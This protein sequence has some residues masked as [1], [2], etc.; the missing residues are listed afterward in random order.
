MDDFLSGY[1]P[2]DK[3]KVEIGDLVYHP[4]Y[5][6][7]KVLSKR[8]DDEIIQVNFSFGNVIKDIRIGVVSGMMMKKAE[9]DKE[10]TIRVKW[11]KDGKLEKKI[12]R[13][14]VFEKLGYSEEVSNLSEYVWNL[15]KKG[16]RII[17]LSDYSRRNMSIRIH[18][19]FLEDYKDPNDSRSMVTLH[20]NVEYR[21][22][23][24]I[25]IRINTM[26][27]PT[28]MSLE[29][30][31]KHAY[32]FIKGGK[33]YFKMKDSKHLGQFTEI[34]SENEF[35]DKFIYIMYLI[36][37]NEIVAYYHSDIRNYK[38]N[39]HK[40]KNNIRKFIKYSSLN[41]FYKYINDNDISEII[42]NIP[43]EEKNDVMNLYYYINKHDKK[44]FNLGEERFK[45]EKFKDKI[46]D[47]FKKI[48]NI[49]DYVEY[50]DEEIDIFYKK[51]EIEVERKKK[52]F[53]KY[54]GRLYSYFS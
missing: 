2:I 30:E 35:T 43:R 14:D 17:D 21:K 28:I 34:K 6:E 9:T 38:Q 53:L 24:N 20:S 19:L 42:K 11:Y 12:I 52:V 45:F 16:E 47:F 3:K 4:K 26:F 48:L 7:G 51:F 32:D 49:K 29:H 23:K 33:D 27:R 46:R 31:L 5:G 18:L 25:E 54:I 37:I 44:Y 40:F 15:Y 41:H 50:S 13:F 10:S 39:K 1:I 22:T 36:Q 8:S